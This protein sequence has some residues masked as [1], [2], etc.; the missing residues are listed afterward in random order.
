MYFVPTKTLYLS[1]SSLFVHIAQNPI[2]IPPINVI[3][4]NTSTTINIFYQK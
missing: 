1:E 3:T 4:V 2:T